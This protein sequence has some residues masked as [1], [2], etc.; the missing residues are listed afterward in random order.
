MVSHRYQVEI[1][2]ESAVFYTIFYVW[3]LIIGQALDKTGKN[4]MASSFFCC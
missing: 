2:S 4:H 3:G 1:P